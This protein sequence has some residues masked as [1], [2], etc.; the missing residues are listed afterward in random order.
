MTLRSSHS[1]HKT[2]ISR[3]PYRLFG[4]GSPAP[5]KMLEFGI[6][7]GSPMRTWGSVLGWF[8]RYAR[9]RAHT[10]D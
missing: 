3:P 2:P 7:F 9:L 1:Y 6:K 8:M 10:L 4:A 5:S